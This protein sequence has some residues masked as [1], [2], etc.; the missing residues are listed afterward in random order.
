MNIRSLSPS[1]VH[2]L[3]RFF[4]AICADEDTVSYFHPHSFDAETAQRI[5]NRDGIHKDRYFAAFDGQMIVGYAMLRGWDEGYEMPSFG[6]CVRPDAR[7]RGIARSLL[8]EALSRARTAGA[9]RMMLK[10]YGENAVARRLYESMGFVFDQPALPGI[11]AVGIAV[12][13]PGPTTPRD[14][15]SSR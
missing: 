1:D 6:V 14:P 8:S 7:G 13:K 3:T 11:Q 10:A 12:L 15:D 9:C 2:A 4:A 5:C